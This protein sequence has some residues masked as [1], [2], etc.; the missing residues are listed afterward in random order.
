M[1]RFNDLFDKYISK[2]ATGAERLEFQEMLATDDYD[3]QL[4]IRIDGYLNSGISDTKHVLLGSGTEILEAVF[5]GDPIPVQAE[6]NKGR[7]LWLRISAAAVIV[8]GLGIGQFYDRAVNFIAEDHY[9]S[10][11]APGKNGATLTLGDGR[12][13]LINEALAGKVAEEMGVRIS[14][15]AEG[16][17]VYEVL[18]NNSKILTYHTLTTTRGEQGQVRL[19]DGTLVFLNAESS[20]RY[21]SSF[22]RSDKRE[23]ML[24]GEGYF[25]VSKDK[26]HPFM[27]RTSRQVVEVLGTHFNVSAYTRVPEVRTTL[28]EGS[29]QVK[30]MDGEVGFLKPGEQAVYAG[31]RLAVAPV[32]TG[33]VVA[34]KEGYFMFDQEPLE[35]IMRK[36]SRWYDIRVVYKEESVRELVLYASFSRFANFATVVKTL[37]RTKLVEME[38]KGNTVTISRRK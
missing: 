11:I 17:L 21:P 5:A 33:D 36:L 28:L 35:S 13:I 1:E 37:E 31:R 22:T 38:V 19:P 3:E 16:H 15:N 34:W 20:L 29:V 26:A 14:K 9:A 10:A 24:T 2:K 27:V 25:E 8:C 32:N 18:E 30:G 12:K 7:R 4:K 23:V 6:N